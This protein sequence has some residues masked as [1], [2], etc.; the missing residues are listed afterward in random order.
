MKTSTVRISTT[1]P[2]LAT[3]GDAD[4]LRETEIWVLDHGLHARVVFE[5][6]V[7][8][9]R[10]VDVKDLLVLAAEEALATKA[11]DAGASRDGADG[12]PADR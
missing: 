9:D 12:S 10:I 4:Q 5:G 11:D 3:S 8:V 7:K 1:R 2:R 6:A